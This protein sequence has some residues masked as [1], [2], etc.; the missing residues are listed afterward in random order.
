MNEET[1]MKVDY[2]AH[3]GD[4]LLVV[5][6]ARCSFD[7]ESEYDELNRLPEKDAKLL[8]FL[9][10]EG[11]WLPFRHP[12]LTLR[13]HAP[14]FV[15]RQLD[16]HQIGFSASE[17]SRRYVTSEPEFY[18]FAWRSRPDGNIKQGSGDPM[19]MHKAYTVTQQYDKSVQHALDTYHYMLAQGVA[20]EQARAVLP[21]SMYTTQ[22]KTG[23]LLGWMQMVRLRTDAHA[24]QEIQDLMSRI[25]PQLMYY[26]PESVKVLREHL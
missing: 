26:F 22:V 5:N 13:I 6:A 21:Q 3:S 15:L 23:S 8:N 2:M 16:K 17:I 25:L 11:H 18:Q 10:R 12:Q 14:L 19:G 1:A 7:K 20:P 9:A 24:Q 4:D